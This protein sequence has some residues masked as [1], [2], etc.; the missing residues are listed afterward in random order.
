[1]S[2]SVPLNEASIPS[3]RLNDIG[4]TAIGPPLKWQNLPVQDP[5]ILGQDFGGIKRWGPYACL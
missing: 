1:M 2:S 3:W 5:F 4:I